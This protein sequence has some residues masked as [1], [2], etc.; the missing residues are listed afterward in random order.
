MGTTRYETGAGHP[1]DHFVYRID[2]DT[3]ARTPYAQAFSPEA[4]QRIRV[5]LDALERGLED[6]DPRARAE[7][8]LEPNPFR[9][10]PLA[11]VDPPGRVRRQV[12]NAHGPGVNITQA[13]GD[14]VLR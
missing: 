9:T 8:K 12:A 11:A 10:N 14:V 1:A 3:G 4:A 2:G 5:A 7:E 6:M 13:G